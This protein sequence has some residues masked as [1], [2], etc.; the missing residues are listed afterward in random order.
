MWNVCE[1]I[2][3]CIY[4][5]AKSI[6]YVSTPIGFSKKL[7]KTVYKRSNISYTNKNNEP[8]HPDCNLGTCPMTST[9]WVSPDDSSQFIVKLSVQKLVGCSSPFIYLFLLSVTLYMDV[10]LTCIMNSKLGFPLGFLSLIEPLLVCL[11]GCHP[12]IH[13][14]WMLSVSYT[15][16]RVDIVQTVTVNVASNWSLRLVHFTG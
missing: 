13:V 14:Q 3:H 4:R 16:L 12:L 8:L 9:M 15:H 5:S 7:S 2:L 11:L 6:E 1:Q 10:L